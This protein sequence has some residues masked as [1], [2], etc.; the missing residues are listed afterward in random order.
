M[1]HQFA[2]ALLTV[3]VIFLAA[4]MAANAAVLQADY[5]T[6]ATLG[7]TNWSNT[8]G[9]TPL[10]LD[11][12]NK[13]LDWSFNQTGDGDSA[14]DLSPSSS[15]TGDG[16]TWTISF[17]VQFGAFDPDTED[18][19]MNLFFNGE[20]ETMLEIQF[21]DWG[22]YPSDSMQVNPRTDILDPPDGGEVD[23]VI[24][25]LALDTWHHV[26]IVFNRSGGTLVGYSGTTQDMADNTIDLWVDGDIGVYGFIIDWQDWTI[27][28]DADL[29]VMEFYV[30]GGGDDVGVGIFDNTVV[31][32]GAHVVPE[33]ATMTMLALGGLAALRRRRRR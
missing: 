18:P 29:D 14:W 17:D 11:T 23:A 19:F 5:F 12:V 25:D 24:G 8:Y 15:G 4:P 10:T 13:Q 30:K 1:R 21:K 28:H 26:D 20:D 27:P 2:L 31:S 32:S 33:P 22:D 6:E 7:D 3:A 9:G 16:D